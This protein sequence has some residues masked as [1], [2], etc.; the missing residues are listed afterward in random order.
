MVLWSRLS[1]RAA[2]LSSNFVSQTLLCCCLQQQSTIDGAALYDGAGLFPFS[3]F[4]ECVKRARLDDRRVL[5]VFGNADLSAA[6]VTARL[7]CRAPL[8]SPSAVPI[9][10]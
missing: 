7:A 8:T 9:G 4:E 5:A 3:A 10:D 2:A 1:T 6:M